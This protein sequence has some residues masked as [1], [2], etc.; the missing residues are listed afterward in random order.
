MK[1][2]PV[3]QL[4]DQLM[5][6]TSKVAA[7]EG[8]ETGKTS[9]ASEGPRSSENSKD[10]KNQVPGQ[11]VDSASE[12]SS[13]AGAGEN[14][15]TN[16]IGVKSGPTGE[17]VPAVKTSLPDPGTSHP[18]KTG[19]EKYST[20]AKLINGAE[21]IAAR[22]IVYARTPKQAAVAPVATPAATPAVPAAP[23][24][25]KKSEMPA[26]LAAAIAKKDKKDKKP[27]VESPA[28]PAAS[29][30]ASE[31]EK[32]A[33]AVLSD[34]GDL[35]LE[36][37][38]AL[39][40]EMVGYLV[41]TNTVDTLLKTA[42]PTEEPKIAGMTEAEFNKLAQQEAASVFDAAN[43]ASSDL[44]HFLL[45]KQAEELPPEAL[46]AAGVDPAAAAGGGAPMGAAPAGGAPMPGGDAGGGVDPAMLDQLVQALAAEGITPEDLM[47]AA[48]DGD[49]DE[50]SNP[51][52]PSDGDGDAVDDARAAALGEEG[53]D[54]DSKGAKKEASVAEVVQLVKLASK[55][56]AAKAARVNRSSN[57]P[58]TEAATLS[59]KVAA[60]TPAPQTASAPGP[61]QQ[62]VM[63]ANDGFTNPTDPGKVFPQPSN[64]LAPNPATPP[65]A[66]G[67]GGLDLGGFWESLSPMQKA[68]LIGGG[69]L[70]VGAAGYGLG[71]MGG[72][73]RDDDSE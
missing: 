57:R 44:I 59:T 40:D 1:N 56:R 12:A 3:M 9:P 60:P 27:A 19:T 73:K 64:P 28:E 30:P 23:V 43:T 5:A 39:W 4:L 38:A 71:S 20:V 31:E 49:G 58:K 48:G 62:D 29:E 26:P 18:A 22:A 21:D 13:V 34:T 51:S 42:A 50:G 2:D 66:G 32:M 8:P 52:K 11:A 25:E 65:A 45:A 46:A 53:S 61:F 72:K 63:K 6:G 69:A 47:A 14:T 67:S 36:K 10:V 37:K 33:A 16:S 7:A 24:A 55:A 17:G 68:M 54:D 70:G 15:A 41:G 35:T